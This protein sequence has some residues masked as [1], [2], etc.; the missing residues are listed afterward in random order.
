MGD[1]VNWNVLAGM[2]SELYTWTPK[3][4]NNKKVALYSSILVSWISFKKNLR[5]L[6]FDITKQK[7]KVWKNQGGKKAKGKKQTKH[8]Y[9]LGLRWYLQLSIQWFMVNFI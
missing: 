4:L 2:E 9:F 5:F 6:I 3:S 1:T 7:V 8:P